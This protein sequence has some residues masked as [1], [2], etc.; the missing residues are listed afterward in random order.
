MWDSSFGAVLGGGMTSRTREF[1]GEVL[2]IRVILRY[3]VKV[4]T[5]HHG[6]EI[7]GVGTTDRYRVKAFSY[8]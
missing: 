7:I 3:Y 1:F 4:T 5:T 6:G 2:G 8:S